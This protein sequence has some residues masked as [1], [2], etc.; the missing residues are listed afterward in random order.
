MAR[1]C[2]KGSLWR[3]LPF[4]GLT[5]AHLSTV[6][7]AVPSSSEVERKCVESSSK[8]ESA[9]SECVYD[10]TRGTPEVGLEILHRVDELSN[11]RSAWVHFFRGKLLLRHKEIE[12]AQDHF[13]EV[14]AYFDISD[15]LKGRVDCRV[16][17][18]DVHVANGDLPSALSELDSL[19]QLVR[20]AGDGREVAK[21][22]VEASYVY[23][24][25]LDFGPAHRLLAELSKLRT[26]D[27]ESRCGRRCLY[28]SGQVAMGLGRYEEAVEHF[29]SIV[30]EVEAAGD[31]RNLAGLMAAR[32]AARNLFLSHHAG[33][34][35]EAR[36][37]QA[38]QFG[39]VVELAEKAGRVETAVRALYQRGKLL[40]GREAL[41][42]LDKC[43]VM[44]DQAEVDEF[45]VRCRLARALRLAREDPEAA[46]LDLAE[47]SGRVEEIWGRPKVLH[48]SSDAIGAA[49]ILDSSEDAKE[50]SLSWL[51]IIEA[52]TDLHSSSKSQIRFFDSWSDTHEMVL[53]RLLKADQGGAE[54]LALA[55]ELKEQIRAREL[56]EE[57]LRN[58]VAPAHSSASKGAVKKRDEIDQRIVAHNQELLVADVSAE[59]HSELHA[60]LV[61]LELERDA[62]DEELVRQ[63]PEL[64]TVSAAPASIEAV[65]AALAPDEA[66]LS[67]QIS[68][69]EDIYGDF[70]GGSWILVVTRD[71]TQ[72]VDLGDGRPL[73]R[74]A[75]DF[76]AQFGQRRG[77]RRRAIQGDRK[78]FAELVAPAIAVLPPEVDRLV[79]VPDG[80]LHL[81]PFGALRDAQDQVLA[82]R[83]VLS[84]VPSAS[85]WLRWR[86]MPRPETKAMALVLADP[87]TPNTSASAA[88]GTVLRDPAR[89]EATTNDPG[90]HDTGSLGAVLRG[91][92]DEAGKLPPLPAARLEGEAVVD[93]LGGG[94]RLLAGLEASERALKDAKLADYRI[95]HVAAHAIVEEENPE[96]SAVFLAPGAENEDGL[97]QIREIVDLDLDGRMVVLSACSS[98]RGTVLRGEGVMSLARAFFA[99]GAPAVIGSL[100]PVADE[101]ARQL[102]DAFY[103]HLAQGASVAEALRSAQLEQIAAGISAE[104]WASV[105]VFGDGAYVPFPRTVGV[106]WR[107]PAF[108]PV[109][110]LLL[111][112]LL[113][114][115]RRIMAQ[116]AR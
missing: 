63:Q 95:L 21:F 100:W 77:R 112:V 19:E 73:A 97:L 16:G 52:V 72:V 76:L 29:D 82:Q 35:E 57:L 86:G 22:L 24:R 93:H 75:E 89:D 64:A 88:S 10:T 38:L 4:L 109:V 8:E 99:A 92:H 67:Y 28:Q 107:A 101:P 43:V 65:A 110:G 37:S 87:V 7:M 39:R 62:V 78:L 54:N 66:L 27:G 79:V 83:F 106:F 17:Q 31:L 50:T 12:E 116:T 23:I 14:C 81:L 49:W 3:S 45:Q 69:T 44:A 53:G 42:E 46:R 5:L 47:A 114:V 68:P 102:F 108:L 115:R 91:V 25:E 2:W 48:F 56:R 26:A 60:S 80:V 113:L 1:L 55:F 40:M 70:A 51:R 30:T 85:L 61:Q 58:D 71:A 96:R 6:V 98:A 13:R 74:A 59:K 103:R 84:I 33:D 36:R 11:E 9:F 90:A 20:S 41:S 32:E 18:I 104:D 111:L 15:L 34:I 94:S 105:E